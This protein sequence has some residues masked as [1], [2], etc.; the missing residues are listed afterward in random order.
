MEL[1]NEVYEILEELVHEIDASGETSG[2][3]LDVMEASAE[4]LEALEF[5]I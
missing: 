1:V 5:V 3:W 4:L 2:E